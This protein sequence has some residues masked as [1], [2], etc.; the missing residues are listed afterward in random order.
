MG[1]TYCLMREN[2]HEFG[3]LLLVAESIGCEV[4]VN[5][6]VTPSRFSLYTLPPEELSRIADGMEKQST[7]LARQ[8]RLNKKV[9]EEHVL[10]LRNNANERQ[11]Q[12]LGGAKQ[13]AVDG[14]RADPEGI[15]HNLNAAEDFVQRGLYDKALEKLLQMPEGHPEYYRSVVMSSRIRRMQGDLEG[16]E[17]DLERAFRL[18]MR[19]PEAFIS[20]AWLR[21]NQNR[22]EEGIEDAVRARE[23]EGKPAF[24]R[25]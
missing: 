15:W 17:R 22:V 2:W 9:W 24:D 23:R 14:W 6:V 10:N 7:A 1:L 4:F 18:S 11:A 25:A 3:D 20:R 16:A 13:A 12:A 5:T 8:L 21:L 19:L